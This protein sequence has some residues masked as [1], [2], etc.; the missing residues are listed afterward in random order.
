MFSEDH[1]VVMATS[2]VLGDGLNTA[3]LGGRKK[4]K[5]EKRK[6]QQEEPTWESQAE[7]DPKPCPTEF[8][9]TSWTCTACP[10]VD[11]CSCASNQAAGL[12]GGVFVCHADCFQD[13]RV[14]DSV[15]RLLILLHLRRRRLPRV[16]RFLCT[17]EE[18]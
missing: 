9:P 10:A 4:K 2:C 6:C 8:R 11:S 18:T 13:V 15:Q 16:S 12:L 3:R 17:A 14:G 7:A 5:R 1:T